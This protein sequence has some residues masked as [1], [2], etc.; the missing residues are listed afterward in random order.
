MSSPEPQS[1]ADSPPIEDPNDPYRFGKPDHPVPPEFAPPGY[2]ADAPAA[3]PVPPPRHAGAPPAPG[4]YPPPPGTYPPLPPGTYPP[5]PPG[6]YPPPPPGTYP[7]PPPGHYPPSPYG[8]YGAPPQSASGK[9]I[10]CLVLGIVAIVAS[11]FAYLDIVPVLL[12]VIFGVQ[13]LNNPADVAGRRLAKA[14]II[15]AIVGALLAVVF[16]IQ[17]NRVVDECGGWSHIGDPG[18]SQCVREN[19]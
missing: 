5:P 14:G 8:Q 17:V 2:G 15:C 9:A 18:F 10:A 7:P 11:V 4:A 12:A 6:T 19:A 16:A 13:S 1:G 3:A